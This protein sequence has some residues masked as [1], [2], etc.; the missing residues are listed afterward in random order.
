MFLN[1]FKNNNI[2][3][4]KFKKLKYIYN[5]YLYKYFKNFY[6]FNKIKYIKYIF[7]KKKYNIINKN[8]EF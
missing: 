4:L 8:L 5:F 6:F 7:L 3:Y 2:F 1:F